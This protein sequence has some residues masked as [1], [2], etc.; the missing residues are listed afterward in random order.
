MIDNE[1][2]LYS[3]QPGEIFMVPPV[4]LITFQSDKQENAAWVPVSERKPN[5]KVNEQGGKTEKLLPLVLLAYEDGESLMYGLGAYDPA[6]E[7]WFVYHNDGFV[8]HIYPIREKVT[9]WAALPAL[10]K[11]E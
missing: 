11:K 6:S 3:V 5:G 9:H 10:P 8:E 1:S 7:K 4:K 2:V